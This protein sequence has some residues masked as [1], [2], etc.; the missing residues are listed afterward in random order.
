VEVSMIDILGK[1]LWSKDLGNVHA[2][3]EPVSLSGLA[4]GVYLIKVKAGERSYTTR[5]VKQ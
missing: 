2:A 3:A 5:V 4:S 1:N